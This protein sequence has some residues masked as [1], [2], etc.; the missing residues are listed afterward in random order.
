MILLASSRPSDYPSH[1]L[2]THSPYAPPYT[3]KPLDRLRPRARSN[4]RP[5]LST[6][7]FC[8]ESQRSIAASPRAE[9]IS[10]LVLVRPEAKVLDGLP[11]ILGSTEQQGV[12]AG[13]CAQRELVER[14][15][16]AASGGNAGTCRGG[17]AKRGD[18]ELRQR[19]EAAVV[20]D[21]AD[22]DD[23]LALVDGRVVLLARGDRDDARH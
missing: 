20:G 10:Y 23:G 9:L 7:G 13:R 21:G 15:A 5:L 14:Q 17:E 4:F 11:R 8:K 18:G 16:L 2:G 1:R 12:G 19:E 6:Y 3:L 22:D